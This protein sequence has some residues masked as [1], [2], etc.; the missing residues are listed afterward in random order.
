MGAPEVL[1]QARLRR[2]PRPAR[3]AVRAGRSGRPGQD[4]ATRDG[5]AAHGAGRGTAGARAGA[6][7][8][9]RA[10]AGRARH[11]ARPASGGLGRAAVGGRARR[12]TSRRRPRVDSPVSAPHRHCVNWPDQPE[13][14]SRGPARAHAVRVRDSG[15]GASRAPAEPGFRG[16]V[17]AGGPQ[18]PAAVP[19]A[20]FLAYEEPA[21][22]DRDAG[23][24][25]S[26]RGVRS[27]RC[28]GPRLGIRARRTGQPVAQRHKK[29]TSR[30]TASNAAKVLKNPKA[31][32]AAKSA[33]GSA[34]AQSAGKHRK[35]K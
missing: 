25:S 14:G 8:A 19:L 16:H 31:S 17:R 33:A 11:A 32:K 26:D 15:R 3:R 4:A 7:V 28:V 34:L 23:A 10:V 35:K 9:G 30:T 20:D 24:A 1:R 29:V 5:R 22:R 12:R 13:V 21:P 2:P 18:Q 27:A 6:E